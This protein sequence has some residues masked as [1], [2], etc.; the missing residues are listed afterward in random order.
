[1]N[2]QT[3]YD[4][5]FS[6]FCTNWRSHKEDGKDY[7]FIVFC[8]LLIM[9][10]NEFLD[11]GNLVVNISLTFLKEEISRSTRIQYMLMFLALDKYVS[12]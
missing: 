10:Q 6:S 5:F 7:S 8:D 12:T 4:V 1:M 11:E 3:P 2:L 9:D